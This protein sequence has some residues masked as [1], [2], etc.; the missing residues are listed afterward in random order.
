MTTYFR[1]RLQNVQNYI[2]K[3]LALQ[4]LFNKP[5]CVNY[6]D[7]QQHTGIYTLI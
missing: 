7:G 1:T 3:E 6:V 2:L 4:P 5:C